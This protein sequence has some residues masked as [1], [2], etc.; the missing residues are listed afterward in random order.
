MGPN[1]PV[2]PLVNGIMVKGVLAI[3]GLAHA[4][5]DLPIAEFLT[6]KGRAAV[7]V[8]ETSPDRGLS[9]VSRMVRGRPPGE[10]LAKPLSDPVF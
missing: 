6:E 3:A 8:A 5:P 9:S 7:R 10:L 4:R 2:L 1:T